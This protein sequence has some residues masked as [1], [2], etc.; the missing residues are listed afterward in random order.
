M[1][2]RTLILCSSMTFVLSIPGFGGSRKQAGM[3][4]PLQYQGGSLP[5]RQN[6]AVNA[7]VANQEVVFVQHGH[8]FAV[9]VRNISE[10]SCATDVRRRFGGAVLRLVPFVD[11][12]K[13]EDHYV[14]VTW[15]GS[16]RS[17]DGTVAVEVLLKLNHGQYGDFVA[18]LERLTGKKAV[19]T[20]KTPTVVHYDL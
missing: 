16:T 4:Y 5:L 10:I 11:L 19:D 1:R 2:F 20:N 14:G 7:V 13:V 17:A 6:H 15:T 8:R 9:P 12:D 3:L 18:T